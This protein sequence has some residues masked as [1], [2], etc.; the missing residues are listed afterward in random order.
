MSTS[1]DCFATSLFYTATPWQ[2]ES[3]V[4]ARK[5][6]LYYSWANFS[7]LHRLNPDQLFINSSSSSLIGINPSLEA[8]PLSIWVLTS[9]IFGEGREAR[10]CSYLFR[11]V[12]GWSVF[13]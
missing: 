11:I 2:N 6:K 8:T 3:S 4:A 1:P 5:S 9:G 13:V 10:P 12:G 7:F